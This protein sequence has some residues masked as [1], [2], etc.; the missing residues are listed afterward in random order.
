M[1]STIAPAVRAPVSASGNF[2]D[3][4]LKNLVHLALA[5][6]L[7]Q[8]QWVERRLEKR[9]PYPYPIYLTPVAR[10]GRTPEGKTIVVMGKHIS[11]H[12]LDFYH[13]EPLPYR[14][15]IA[16]L[17]CA[18]GEWLGILMD[19]SWCRFCRHGWYDNGGRFLGPATSPLED[20]AERAL[21]D[22]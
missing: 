16:S 11:E 2:A 22:L 5:N 8:R 17:G 1:T 13:R 10:D 21:L 6:P 7:P 19:L 9:H 20:P 15:V 4:G 3:E 12:G 18:S 14:R